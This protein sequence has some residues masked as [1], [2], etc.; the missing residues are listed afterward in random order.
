MKIRK[1][2]TLVGMGAAVILATA[3]GAWAAGPGSSDP[4]FLGGVIAIIAIL[5]GLKSH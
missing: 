1:M 2:V 3:P 5:I 4:S